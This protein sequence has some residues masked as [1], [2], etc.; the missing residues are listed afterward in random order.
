MT[1][2]VGSSDSVKP[3]DGGYPCWVDLSTPD[4]AAARDFYGALFGW[5]FEVLDDDQT[6]YAIALKDGVPAAGLVEQP[7]VGFAYWG[8]YLSVPDVASAIRA[9]SDAG[10]RCLWGPQQ[11]GPLA[12][13]ATVAD[14][15]G[16]SVGLWE[17]VE[18]KGFGTNGP[19]TFGMTELATPDR[20]VSADYFGTVFGLQRVGDPVSGFNVLAKGETVVTT[21]SAA[22]D[23]LATWRTYFEVDDVEH[24]L[25]EVV[26]LGG[27]ILVPPN[28][29]AGAGRFAAVA[30][31]MGARFGLVG[32]ILET[33][34]AFAATA[35]E[36]ADD[37]AGFPLHL[38][39]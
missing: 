26:R 9:G 16:V 17:P 11:V 20:D 21:V 25:D 29:L 32:P 3:D 12:R 23:D 5:S 18:F 39:L 8:L 37:N 36:E 33:R 28:D 34:E 7:E 1:S 6:G 22:I 27:T 24:T 19:G 38:N 30:D 15:A 31:P 35:S 4:L 2:G 13:V 10:G 14:P